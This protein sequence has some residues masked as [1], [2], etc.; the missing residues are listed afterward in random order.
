[1]VK[2]LTQ[3][4]TS[5][6]CSKMSI[7]LNNQVKSPKAFVLLFSHTLPILSTLPNLL[8]INYSLACDLLTTL[9]FTLL[10]QLTHCFREK[11]GFFPLGCEFLE[12]GTALFILEF[13]KPGIM[14]PTS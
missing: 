8:T 14:S 7:S 10:W 1:M 5:L 13:P 12:A 9:H 4:H 6:A 3:S 11:S 2:I